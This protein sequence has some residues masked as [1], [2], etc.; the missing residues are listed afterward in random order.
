MKK[1]ERRLQ[2]LLFK[3]VKIRLI[4]F[5]NELREEYGHDCP[6]TGDKVIEHPYGQKDIA[7]LIW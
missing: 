4:E 7:S 6:K 3:Y 1:L 2:L 5:I